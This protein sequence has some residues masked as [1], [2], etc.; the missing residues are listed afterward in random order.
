MALC[1]VAWLN[2]A[3]AYPC[4]EYSG[5]GTGNRPS[6]KLHTTQNNCKLSYT[7][8]NKGNNINYYKG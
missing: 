8:N 3:E 1:A 2:V 6:A 5:S 7:C 4:M